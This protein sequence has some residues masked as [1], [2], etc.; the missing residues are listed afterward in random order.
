MPGEC[1]PYW[2]IPG[3]SRLVRDFLY[4]F[5]R[6]ARFYRYDPC[7]REAVFRRLENMQYPTDR[8]ARLVEVLRVQNPG[9]EAVERLAEPSTVAVVTGQ[10]VGL[11]TGPAYTFYKALTAMRVAEELSA[12]GVPA[13][14]IFWMATED[15]DYS[16]VT[17][18]W[19]FDGQGRPVRIEA[20][21][22][23]GAG[24][25][26]VGQL[27]L[28]DWSLDAAKEAWREAPH[29]GEALELATGAYRPGRPWAAAFAQLLGN[30]VGPGR[31]L[32]FDPLEKE[33][34][35]FLAPALARAA[36]QAGVLSSAVRERTAE[37]ERSGYEAQVRVGAE[38]NL[39]FIVADGRRVRARLRDGVLEWNG[40]RLEG[41]S[42]AANA[43]Y[44]SAAALLRPVVQDWAFPAAVSV[45]GPAEIAYLGQASALYEVLG[46]GVPVWRLRASCTLVD[47]VAAE[48]LE[49]YGL[50]LR[51]F[52]GSEQ[53][54]QEAVG[55]RLR[56]AVMVEAL[57]E[58]VAGVVA[59]LDRIA[60]ALEGWRGPVKRAFEKSRAKILYQLGKIQRGV[61]REAL[62]RDR[63]A[64]GEL[65]WLRDQLYP[66]RRLQERVYSIMA[67]VARYGTDLGSAL[68]ERV[69]WDCRGHQTVVL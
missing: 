40:L 53:A 57:E 63:R 17:E 15:H 41:P 21:W 20:G 23:E 38:A 69:A 56:P 2:Q 47:K 67:F 30:L 48:V 45:V 6:V 34:R 19:V 43:K 58:S 60:G 46:V 61:A 51:D 35:E 66:R 64:M 49:R 50:G 11:L 12:M 37:L 7:D 10:Q 14:P 59:S 4:S 3:A 22:C 5:D 32:F 16:E 54:L 26:S 55:A 29:G 44:L 31:L 62:R 33:A 68:W 65:Q 28:P 8:R 39:F 13:V 52:F 42:L 9:C 1:I 27:L 25:R 18:C 24:S 36:E